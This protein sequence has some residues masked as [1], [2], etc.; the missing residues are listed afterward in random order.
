MAHFAIS[1]AEAVCLSHAGRPPTFLQNQM[2][3]SGP[4][5]NIQD[6]YTKFRNRMKKKD[7]L[8]RQRKE[9]THSSPYVH[10]YII[11]KAVSYEMDGQAAQ[12]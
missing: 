12:C 10:L 2:Q 11:W 9:K 3:T 8:K 4:F 7:S 6:S 5:T 1:V